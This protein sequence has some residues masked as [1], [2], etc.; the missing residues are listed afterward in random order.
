MNYGRDELMVIA[1]VRYCLGRMSYIVGD[2]ADWLII[3]WP[4]LQE[5][6]RKT[7]QRDV[8]AEF[9]KDDYAR[10]ERLEHMPLGMDQDRA[11]WERVRRLWKQ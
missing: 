1:A 11:Q 3:V 5:S 6:T 7:I 9:T 2:C 4:E 8:E 10:L